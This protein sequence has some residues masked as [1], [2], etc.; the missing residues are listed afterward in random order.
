MK[1]RFTVI[2]LGRFGRTVATTLAHEGAEV[3]AIDSDMDAIERIK[4][5][6]ALA[7]CLDGEDNKA[8]QSQNIQDFD[9]VIV[10]IGNNFESMLLTTVNLMNLEVPRIIARAMNK[11]QRSILYKLGLSEQDVISPEIQVGE[12][13][14]MGLL[15]PDIKTVLQL[16]DQYEVAKVTTP[17]KVANQSIIE[18]DMRKKFNI[19]LIAI[20]REVSRSTEDEEHESQMQLLGITDP[21]TTILEQDSLILIGKQYDI[22][23]FIDLNS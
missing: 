6:V 4:D 14:A 3:M 23:K 20:E 11:T 21:T 16:A 8:L 2:G 13:V 1:N 10:A 9:V 12:T 19:N 15:Q 22:Q 18:L 17:P 7:V 5:E